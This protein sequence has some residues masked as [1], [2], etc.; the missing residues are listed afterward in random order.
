MANFVRIVVGLKKLKPEIVIDFVYRIVKPN[1]NAKHRH[2]WRR[3][4]KLKSEYMS[5][6][7][8]HAKFMIF[9][10][11]NM[12]VVGTTL[13]SFKA[14]Q[15]SNYFFY[16]ENTQAIRW[17]GDTT[18]SLGVIDLKVG[19]K[20][21]LVQTNGLPARRK[22]MFFYDTID[23]KFHNFVKRD[24]CISFEN[25]KKEGESMTLAKCHCSGSCG[26]SISSKQEIFVKYF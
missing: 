25:P 18:K 26:G 22:D 11:Q 5:G 14:I 2:Y 9:N 10:S 6:L 16:D 8:N 13:T 7:K 21:Q 23:M 19:G 3:Y 24:L 1:P 4:P 15:P 17:L 12:I 20:I